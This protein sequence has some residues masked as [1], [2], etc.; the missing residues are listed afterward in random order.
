MG[1]LFSTPARSSVDYRVEHMNEHIKRTLVQPCDAIIVGG[2]DA[3]LFSAEVVELISRR[4][5]AGM[6]LVYVDPKRG[7]E[8]VRPSSEA[9]S[10]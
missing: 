5:T 7:S 9:A 10:A 2:L 3:G 6:G 8:A 4:V 1:Y